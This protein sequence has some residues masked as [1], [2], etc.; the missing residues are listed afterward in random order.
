MEDQHQPESSTARQADRDIFDTASSDGDHE[1]QA[2]PQT[3]DIT[4]R[5]HI[6]TMD[7]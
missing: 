3:C 2:S 4:S 1:L 5:L 6:T 7:C